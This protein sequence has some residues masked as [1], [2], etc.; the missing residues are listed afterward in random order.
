MFLFFISCTNSLFD[1]NQI[2]LKVF[3]M[4]FYMLISLGN[5]GKWGQKWSKEREKWDETMQDEEIKEWRYG[6]R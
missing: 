6:E 2:Y 4:C 3:P 5:E 1:F